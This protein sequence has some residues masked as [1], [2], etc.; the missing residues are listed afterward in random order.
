LNSFKNQRSKPWLR[1]T[2]F[3]LILSLNGCS[4]LS[5]ADTAISAAADVVG[6]GVHAAS[7]AVD[8]ILPGPKK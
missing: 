3:V 5:I 4:V 2:T 8:A 7:S 1:L 6:M